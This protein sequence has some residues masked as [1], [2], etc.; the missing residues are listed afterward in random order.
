MYLTDMHVHTDD[1]PDAEISAEELV[2]SGLEQGLVGIGF[3]A[4]VDLNPE[5]H[6]YDSFNPVSYDAS[7]A[8]A[9]N[10][11]GGEIEVYKGIEVG[12]PH[13]YQ[14]EVQ[15]ALDY[16]SYDFITGALHTVEGV[17]MVLGKSPFENTDPLEV[18]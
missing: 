14:D 15:R 18:V 6:C 1:S 3:V 12:E 2:V 16:S 10:R 8:L 4:H 5:D 11:A 7:L 17:G 9:R 13:I